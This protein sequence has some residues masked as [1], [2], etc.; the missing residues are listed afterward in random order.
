MSTLHINSSAQ[1]LNSN[2]REI[3]QYLADALKAPVTHRD[4]AL[5]PL[6]AISSEDLIGVQTTSEVERPSLKQ[7]LTL[8][9]E[10]ISELKQADTLI[11]GAPMYNFGIPANLKQW[12][13]A[14]CRVGVSFQYSNEGPK[15]LLN[16]ER[17]YIVTATGGT[18]VG[19][20]MDFVSGYLQH[21][22]QFVGTKEVHHIDAG[23]LKGTQHAIIQQ[24]K[25]QIDN[26]LSKQSLVA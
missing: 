9:D 15:G 3:G 25:Q 17:A 18:P 26:I 1:M 6:P 16:I 22:L 20:D 13:D 24:A 8:S 10:L 11:I 23:G 7:H 5:N 12:I 21:V 4:L 19:S 14:I 2:T